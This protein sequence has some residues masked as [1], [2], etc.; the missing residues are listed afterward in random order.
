MPWSPLLQLALR[1]TRARSEPLYT[2]MPESWLPYA[3]LPVTTASVDRL[4]TS[5][6][7]AVEVPPTTRLS[8]DTLPCSTT[9]RE[10]LRAKPW[11]PFPLLV[12]SRTV[13]PTELVTRT[14]TDAE[15]LTWQPRTTTSD[16]VEESTSTPLTPDSVTLTS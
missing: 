10:A 5:K 4:F 9:E 12:Q 16:V 3:E 8:C 1:A 14:P 15:P 6:P 13:V 7:A 11:K 2:W